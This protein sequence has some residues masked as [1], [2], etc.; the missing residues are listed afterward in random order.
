[1]DIFFS[2]SETMM[3]KALLLETRVAVAIQEATARVSHIRGIK[4]KRRTRVLKI[5]NAKKPFFLS[6]FIGSKGE[7]DLCAEEALIFPSAYNLPFY[8]HKKNNNDF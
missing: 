4:K 5:V 2:F 7:C 6:A 8:S 1:V 3:M